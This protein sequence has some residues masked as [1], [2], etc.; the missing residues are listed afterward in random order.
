MPVSAK[1]RQSKSSDDETRSNL[2]DVSVV[3]EHFGL[4]KRTIWRYVA[5]NKIPSHSAGSRR[6]RR[7]DLDEVG[8]ALKVAA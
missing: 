8:A 4:S 2:V 3:A 6:A 5:E 7:F 1:D